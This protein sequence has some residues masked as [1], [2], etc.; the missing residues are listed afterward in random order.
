[1]HGVLFGAIALIALVGG[2]GYLVVSRVRGWR[3]S[4][5]HAASKRGREE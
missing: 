5:R 3:R 2:L 4:D 1:M